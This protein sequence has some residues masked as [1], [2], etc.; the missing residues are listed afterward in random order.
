MASTKPRIL[1][2]G[3]SLATTTGLSYFVRNILT[4]YVK[5]QKYIIGHITIAGKECD[6]NS[7]TL[8]GEDFI[9]IARNVEFFNAQLLDKEK[10]KT[11]DSII[12][13]FQPD[14]VISAHD[15]W[16]IDQIAYSAYKHTFFWATYLT[17]EAPEYPEFVIYPTPAHPNFRKSI[18]NTL[19]SADLCI[20]CTKMAENALK[21]WGLNLSENVYCGVDLSETIKE[22][23]SKSSVFGAQVLE[24]DFVFMTVGINSERKRIDRVVKSFEKFLDKVRETKYDGVMDYKKY[25]LYVHSDFDKSQGGTDLKSLIKQSPY[26]SQIFIP[27]NYQVGIGIKRE[28]LYKKYKASDCYIGLSSGEGFGYGYVE[29]AMHGKPVIYINYGGH[30]EYCS[31][32]GLP[33]KVSEFTYAI[34]ATIEWALSDYNDCANQMI[35]ICTDKKLY[36]KLSENGIKESKKFSWTLINERFYKIVTRYYKE[37]KSQS[38]NTKFYYKR[39]V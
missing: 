15:P 34:N 9:K 7:I 17:I 18:K 30:I 32:F 27:G 26:R 25:K 13:K 38:Q 19:L 28:E 24:D 12:N 37:W 22:D 21:N 33:V 14:I 3:D 36:K 5:T 8:H 2:V 20:P 29:A 10:S 23:I 6:H 31:S 4:H 35:K 1:F 11:F 39:I 16:V